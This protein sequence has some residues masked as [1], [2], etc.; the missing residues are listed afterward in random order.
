VLTA[1]APDGVDGEALVRR[2]A[3]S[4]I[5]LSAG[6][7]EAMAQLTVDYTAARRQFGK[8]IAAFQAVQQHL[9]IAAQ[10]SVRAS[11]AADLAAVALA[12]GDGGFAVAAASVVVDEA[13]VLATRAAHQAHGAMGVTRE[14]SLQHLS[15]RL[16]SWRHEYRHGAAWTLQLGR[17]V[18]DAGADGLFPLITG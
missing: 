17:A 8:P 2:G 1:A 12:R 3:L 11:I 9:V 10:C 5:V 13:S 15:R 14:Y 7:L 18:Q 16:W 4:R 6:A